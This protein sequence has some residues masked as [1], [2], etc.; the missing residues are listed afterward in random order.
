MAIK[1][2]VDEWKTSDAIL[3]I[4]D[5]SK[6]FVREAR[7]SNNKL[8]PKALTETVN[9]V[10]GT[11]RGELKIT[12]SVD[13]AIPYARAYEFGSGKFRTPGKRLP[14]KPQPDGS[15]RIE[16]KTKGKL[17]AFYWDKLEKRGR[18]SRSKVGQEGISYVGDL[19]DGRAAFNYVNHPGVQAANMGKG[20]MKS[21]IQAAYDLN[22]DR[23]A[24]EISES[25]LRNL[26]TSFRKRKPA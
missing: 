16:P 1:S 26:K 22:S 20:Y 21:A 3:R 11:T 18:L 24:K 17:L 12:I 8:L 9:A 14:K 5:D 10:L 13:P 23:L 4:L 2:L 19:K 6:R 25:V 15:Y 7:T